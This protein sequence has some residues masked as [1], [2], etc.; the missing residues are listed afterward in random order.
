MIP[1]GFA[2]VLI[3]ALGAALGSF[4]NVV[5][6]RLPRRRSL[7][8]P[9]SQCP[10]CGTP[11][12]AR[13][14][15]PLL[16][17]LLLRGRCRYCRRPIGWRYPLVELL[18]AVLLTL[19]WLREG[20]TLQFAAAAV[21]V[22]LLIPI[23]FIDLEHRI[24]PNALSYP[25][26]VLGLLLAVPQGRFADA[27]FAGAGA[28]AVFLLIAILSRGGMGGGDIK[29]AVVMG[30]FLGWPAI[31]FALLVAFTTGAL[32]GVV[33]LATGRRGRR[34][35]IPF[36]PFLALGAVVAWLT[37]STVIAWYLR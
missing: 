29:L 13:D 24:V 18:T 35:P 30:A 22:L 15:I 8:S 11:I 19:L 21:F 7:V 37:A 6:Y 17:F 32:V 26:I 12:A 5:I 27:L 1:H 33:L 31:A 16:S 20:P 9:R 25:G 10:S 3:F 28:G 34:D 36:G 4:L 23:F 2:A 14:N